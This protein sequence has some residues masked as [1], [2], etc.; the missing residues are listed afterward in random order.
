MG[1]VKW[2]KLFSLLL[3]PAGLSVLSEPVAHAYVLPAEQILQFMAANFSKTQ[4]LIVHQSCEQTSEAKGTKS[5]DEIL[6]MKAPGLF[7]VET[8][9]SGENRGEERDYS[10][11]RLFLANSASP[12][13]ALMLE[14]GIDIVKVGYTRMDGIVAYRIGEVEETG[15]RVL[16][17]KERFLP[18]FFSYR[19]P[20]VGGGSLAI[21]KFLDY[22]RVEQ[23]WY[24]F[25]ILYSPAEGITEKHKVRFLK[26]NGPVNPSLFGS[27]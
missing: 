11:W 10:Y 1:P 18:L 3:L 25:E 27:K 12:L 26:I 19:A 9:D 15:P 21:V 4:T 5:F 23:A 8:K 20:S 2:R 13:T 16:V 14:R 6:T 24:P 7:H 17:E 22:R